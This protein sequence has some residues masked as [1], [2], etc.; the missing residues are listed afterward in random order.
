MPAATRTGTETVLVVDDAE[1]LRELARTLLVRRG[2]TVLVA[3]N[4]EDALAV[5]GA[6]GAVDL[7]L[8]DLIM[9]GTGGAALS[10]QL[11]ARHPG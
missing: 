3:A 11:L 7:L 9:P 4:A 2:Y 8:T 10:R 5:A 1:G 6:H